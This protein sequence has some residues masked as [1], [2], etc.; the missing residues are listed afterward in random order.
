VLVLSELSP[1]QRS[2]LKALGVPV[3]VVDPFGDLSHEVPAVGTTHWAGGLAA[4]QHLIE[5]GHTRIATISG[6][7]HMLCSRARVDRYRSALDAAGL[8]G[9]AESI[10][11][12]AFAI[13]GGHAETHRLIE[14]P[15]PA[16][17]ICAGSAMMARGA[18]EA[19]FDRGL[20]VPQ[21]VSAV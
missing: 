9:P 5:L 18:Y 19:L 2:Q 11:G 12:G 4:T 3:A 14:P 17:A 7:T 15:E 6:P 21:D 10:G 20:R 13:P 16:T 1:E 8:P